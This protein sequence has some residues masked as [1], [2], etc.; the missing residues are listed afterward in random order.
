MNKPSHFSLFNI[1]TT[2]MTPNITSVRL[3]DDAYNIQRGRPMS[4]TST[5]GLCSTSPSPMDDSSPP[6]EVDY[7]ERVAANCNMD[8]EIADPSLPSAENATNFSFS[9]LA[10][11]PRVP[12][13]AAPNPAVTSYSDPFT[14]PSPPE[15]IPYNTNVPADPSLWN[16][17]FSATSLF[18]TNE[19]LNSNINNIP[20]S[21]KRMA[22][23]LR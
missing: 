8:I 18:G 4:H 22:Y 21:L 19:F 15:V 3:E 17:N 9:L 20:C 5:N 7:A 11:D 10:S 1:L 2:S 14:E 12:P 23:F 13:E 6:S 16:G